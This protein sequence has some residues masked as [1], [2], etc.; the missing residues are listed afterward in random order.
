MALQY[1]GRFVLHE[2]V[3]QL[4]VRCV[5]ALRRMDID[6]ST[7]SYH[8]YTDGMEVTQIAFAGRS[9]ARMSNYSDIALGTIFFQQPPDPVVVWFDD[10]AIDDSRIGCQ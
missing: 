6:V 7:M 2:L 9:G 3:L 1:S 4:D 5:V 8:F 10:L